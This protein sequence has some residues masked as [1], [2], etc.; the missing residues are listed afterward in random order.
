VKEAFR[1][2]VLCFCLA[3]ISAFGQSV[4]KTKTKIVVHLEKPNV[5]SS[6]FAAQPKTIYRAGSRYCRVEEAPDPAHN[7]QGLLIVNEPDAWLIDLVKKIGRH[8]IDP[9][10]TFNCRLPIFKGDATE[11]LEKLEFGQELPYFKEKGIVPVSGPALFGKPTKVYEI[12]GSD[13]QLLLFVDAESGLP[14]AIK[15]GKG[16]D[17]QIYLYSFYQDIPFDLGLFVKPKNVTIEEAK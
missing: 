11:E 7:I 10:P 15:K 8:Q 14:R 2:G 12:D 4:P 9:G 16:T 1:S 5:S 17:W 13:Y 3:T 6:D